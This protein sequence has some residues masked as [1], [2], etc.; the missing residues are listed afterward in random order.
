MKLIYKGG[1]EGIHR[2]KKENGLFYNYILQL[3]SL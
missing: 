2:F 3:F 1:E